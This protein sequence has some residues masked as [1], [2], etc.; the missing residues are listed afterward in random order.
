MTLH[1]GSQQII[2][3]EASYGCWVSYVLEFGDRS[4]DLVRHLSFLHRSLGIPVTQPVICLD[5]DLAG[6]SLLPFFLAPC[7]F[8]IPKLAPCPF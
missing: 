7:P 6:C 8:H 2:D 1:S 3:V 4:A 5:A